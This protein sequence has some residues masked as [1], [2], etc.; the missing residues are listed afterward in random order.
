MIA[1]VWAQDQ[2]GTIGKAG[3]LPWHLPDDLK[4]FKHLTLGQLVAMG[5]TTYEGLPNKPL[6]GRVNLVLTHQPDYQAPG[7]VVVH[8]RA[9]LL[10]YA[11]AHPQQDL[12]IVG[13]AQIFSAF[14]DVVERLYVTKLAGTF[15]GDVKMPAL[16]WQA[17]TQVESREVVDADPAKTHV[18][19]TW[20]RN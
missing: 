7:A 12:M 20:D 16:P 6:P 15:D 4:M 9:S 11:K 19:E 14:A 8:D 5:R 18:F 2:A 10:A 17:F 3:R 13:G 1:F